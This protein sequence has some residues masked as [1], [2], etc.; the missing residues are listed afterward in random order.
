MLLMVQII[1]ALA[2]TII[3][4]KIII[5]LIHITTNQME[6]RDLQVMTNRQPK[7]A[8]NASSQVIMLIN[9]LLT[10]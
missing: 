1:V 6:F 7:Y 10:V 3:I 9:V 2:E 8:L 5:A 4:T